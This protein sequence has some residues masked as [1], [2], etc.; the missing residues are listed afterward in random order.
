MDMDL[1]SSISGMKA[2]EFA[3]K[4]GTAI[5]KKAMDVSE[6]QLDLINQMLEASGIGQNLNV[7]A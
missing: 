5:A 2:A 7:V 1:V 3:V 4:A 6:M